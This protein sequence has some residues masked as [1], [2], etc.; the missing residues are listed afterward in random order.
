[1]QT[2][3]ASDFHVALSE[4]AAAAVAAATHN[5]Q[6]AQHLWHWETVGR[7]VGSVT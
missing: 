5:E 4:A 7:M 6:G 1:M 2:P 3:P